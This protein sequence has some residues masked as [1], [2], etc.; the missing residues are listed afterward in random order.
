M[1]AILGILGTSVLASI[2]SYLSEKGLKIATAIGI[3]ILMFIL[4]PFSLKLPNDVY[5]LFVTGKINLFF[6]SVSYF[7][8]INFLLSCLLVVFASKYLKIY[9]NIIKFLWNKFID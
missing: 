8:P 2:A 7:L 1:S 4:I 6:K 5:S 9:F 3:L